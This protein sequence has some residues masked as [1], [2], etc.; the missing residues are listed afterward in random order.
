MSGLEDIKSIISKLDFNQDG[1]I[2]KDEVANATGK[3]SSVWLNK[4]QSLIQDDGI[5]TEKLIK[6]L[7][8]EPNPNNNSVT[9]FHD[10]RAE[11]EKEDWADDIQKVP[12]QEEYFENYT[13]KGRFDINLS[14]ANPLNSELDF[15]D[16]AWFL[17]NCT[18][19]ENTFANT[20][21]EH[22]PEGYE[23]KQIIELGKNPGLNTRAVHSKGI[24][25]KGV[26]VAIMDW[27]LPPSDNYDSNIVSYKLENNAKTIPET[28]HGAAVTSILAGKETGVAPDAEVYYFAERQA[29]KKGASNE[30]LI[31]SFR[32]VLEINKNL[33]EN[34]KIRVISISG[35]IYGGEEAENLVKE[36]EDS[37]VWV[38]S[39]PEFWK[40]FGYLG[41]KDAM[42]NPDDFDN[43]NIQNP[44][45][46]DGRQLYVN[47]GNR[48]VT[49][50]T[51][52]V[53]Y[54]HDSKASASWA[55]PVVAGYYALA[56]E[57]D[58]SMTKE[59]F[60]EL[61][62][63]TAK[64]KDLGYIRQNDPQG[65]YERHEGYIECL[66]E[67]IQKDY[68]NFTKE[69]CLNLDENVIIDYENKMADFL[70]S[71][72]NLQ[73]DMESLFIKKGK[74]V[75]AARG[76]YDE[77]GVIK[78][79]PERYLPKEKVMQAKIIDIDA[80]IE[81]IKSEKNN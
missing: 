75:L 25:G 46:E 15:S 60:M 58:P 80:L 63:E 66:V 65:E 31:K 45:E 62:E 74:E 38:L 39:S 47:S 16:S 29:M 52:S 30:D 69:Q 21:K 61:A 4:I 54:R 5:S 44:A 73:E 81:R 67:T 24:T 76:E 48:T 78:N 13:R 23:P 20:P 49:H 22:L 77:N 40:N 42:G 59:R 19:S 8:I 55:I 10:K 7:S 64:V 70:L 68:P 6:G 34:E 11:L 53:E 27:Q 71:S 2:S 32:S 18:F 41:K 43:Y 51:N 37:G 9:E 14:I 1:N 56:C 28:M 12:T 17:K 36:L 72:A 26:K 79:I 57:A 50:F 33:P 35:P 3:I